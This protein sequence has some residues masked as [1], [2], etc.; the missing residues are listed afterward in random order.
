T[1]AWVIWRQRRWASV[2]PWLM[3]SVALLASFVTLYF[4]CI[5]PQ[6][7]R[8]LDQMH[9]FWDEHFPPFEHGFAAFAKWFVYVHC[10]DIMAY[11]A[12]GAPYQSTLSTICWL[13]GLLA[14][15]RKR[16]W[17]VLILC[18]A[19][20]TVTFVAAAMKRY[21]YGGHVRLNLYLAPFMCMVIG[22][23][24]ATMLA[25]AARRRWDAAL[26]LN[27]FLGVLALVGVV[28]M[29]RDLATPYKNIS[30]QRARG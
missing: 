3:Y 1:I 23:G 21:P 25:W 13:T 4:L 14:L 8:E 7:A 17:T 18:L 12:G 10:A 28:C 11:P 30:D 29:G 20:Q 9:I 24:A 27:G 2:A 16:S 15:A 19:P 22:Y 5:R 6:A 26:S